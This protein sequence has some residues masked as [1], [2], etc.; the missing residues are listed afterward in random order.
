VLIAKVIAGVVLVLL[1]L[2]V[3]FFAYLSLTS[4]VPKV[5]LTAG[6]LR[7]CPATPNCVSS[8]SD[9]RHAHIAPFAFQGSSQRAWEEMTQAIRADG[10]TIHEDR[11]GYLWATYTSRIFRFVDDVEL[12]LEA[13]RDVIDVRSGSRVGRSDLGVNR[14]RVERLRRLFE[15]RNGGG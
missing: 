1:L 12:Q 8:E 9:D 5:G 15:Q 2:W 4:P 7:P 13:G 3:G 11:D 6:R 14:K 10:G